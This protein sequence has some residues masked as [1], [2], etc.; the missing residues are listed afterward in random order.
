MAH[1]SRVSIS[2]EV[3][4]SPGA[5]QPMGHEAWAGRVLVPDAYLTRSATIEDTAER[6]IT[7]E[8]LSSA[9]IVAEKPSH[10]A[11]R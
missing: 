10:Q 8:Q 4:E 7:A 6:A 9:A 5:P 2:F 1:V 11:S 3:E